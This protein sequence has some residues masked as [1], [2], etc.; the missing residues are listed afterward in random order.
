MRKAKPLQNIMLQQRVAT[1]TRSVVDLAHEG[2]KGIVK[3]KALLRDKVWFLGIN[4]LTEKKVK[5]C[6]AL[7]T[8]HQQQLR[9]VNLCKCLRFQFQLGKKSAWISRTYPR[10]VTS[11]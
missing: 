11:L 7:R 10:N 4:Q 3:T 6:L 5:S 9:N 2:H 1:T 8:K